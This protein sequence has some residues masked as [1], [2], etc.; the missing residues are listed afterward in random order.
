[1]P[2]A[3]RERERERESEYLIS[4]FNALPVNMCGAFLPS[5]LEWLLDPLLSSNFGCGLSGAYQM[6][7][8]CTVLVWLQFVGSSG[9]QETPSVLKERELPHGDHMFDL[10]LVNV[11]GR[12]PE[13]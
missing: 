8:K 3:E 7:N 10:L 11:L 1:M 6:A 2:F 9:R 5:H 4:F 12:I 13:G